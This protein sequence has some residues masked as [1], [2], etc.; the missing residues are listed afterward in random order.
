MVGDDG[1]DIYLVDVDT[2]EVPFG[3]QTTTKSQVLPVIERERGRFAKQATDLVV[4]KLEI[5]S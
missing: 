2:V 5:F 1:G 4:C 3:S